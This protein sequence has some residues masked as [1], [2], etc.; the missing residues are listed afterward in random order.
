MKKGW[1]YLLIFSLAINLF[2]VGFAATFLIGF[3]HLQ[4]VVCMVRSQFGVYPLSFRKQFLAQIRENS[5]AWLEQAEGLTK[6]RKELV[7][8]LRANPD[9]KERIEPLMA[10]VRDELS[11]M[12]VLSQEANRRAMLAISP[13]ERER[14]HLDPEATMKC[15]RKLLKK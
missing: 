13:E 10:K 9:D 12:H 1:R 15:A 11:G 2:I 7:D 14:I 4:P 8:A 3:R 6:A 5:D